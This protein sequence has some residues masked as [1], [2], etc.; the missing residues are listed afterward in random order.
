[1]HQI[2]HAF[3]EALQGDSKGLEALC[4]SNR[5]QERLAIYETSCLG[6]LQQTLYKIYKP[7]AVLLGQETFQELCYRYVKS[8]FSTELNLNRYGADLHEFSKSAP[9]AQNLPYLSDFIEFCYTWQQ[10]Y[11]QG[12][13]GV[14]IESDYPLYE[15]WKRCQPEFKGETEIKD[16]QGPFCYGMVRVDGWVQTSEIKPISKMQR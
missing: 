2:E 4:I 9:F 14:L 12:E 7:L 1:M 10:V 8:H 3:L 6:T 5:F 11:L 16:W 13:E 15:I